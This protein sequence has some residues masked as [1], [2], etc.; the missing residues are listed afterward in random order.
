QPEVLFVEE[1]DHD[2]DGP[3]LEESAALLECAAL[4]SG[5][6]VLVTG[7][8]PLPTVL[9][10]REIIMKDGQL[11]SD[12]STVPG[13]GENASCRNTHPPRQSR[14]RVSQTSPWLL[15]LS[16]KR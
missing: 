1:I 5:T 3:E 11:L 13:A 15:S 2:L 14:K 6:T 9:P 7:R 10:D 4:Q 16:R 12:T 8:N